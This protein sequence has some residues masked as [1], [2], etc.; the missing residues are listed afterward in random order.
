[1]S[2]PKDDMGMVTQRSVDDLVALEHNP[3]DYY[4]YIS[5][6]EG[7][8]GGM[9]YWGTNSREEEIAIMG[10]IFSELFT[11]YPTL[12][13]HLNGILM[14]HFVRGFRLGESKWKPNFQVSSTM[15]TDSV[16][17]PSVGD[18]N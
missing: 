17:Q 1:M 9:W 4:A 14:K 8:E 16:Y 11:H 5:E 3:K 10:R 2:I 13:I 6:V 18:F 12:P 7:K 15:G